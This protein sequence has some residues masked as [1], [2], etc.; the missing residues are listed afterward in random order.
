MQLSASCLCCQK[1]WKFHCSPKKICCELELLVVVGWLFV[2]LGVFLKLFWDACLR[3]GW[4]WVSPTFGTFTSSLGPIV[5]CPLSQRGA[6]SDWT[7]KIP[8]VFSIQHLTKKTNAPLMVV[9]KIA[10]SV[11]IYLE[12]IIQIQHNSCPNLS[13]C[14]LF[15]VS[16][17]LQ[18][19]QVRQRFEGEADV[20]NHAIAQETVTTLVG[21][22]GQPIWMRDDEL[23]VPWVV[24]QWKMVGYIPKV[25]ILLEIYTS[26][27][28]EKPYEMGQEGNCLKTKKACTVTTPTICKL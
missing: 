3:V 6:T 7:S 23:L 2:F 25:T 26:I 19:C 28:H 13:E 16:S 17:C 4:F 8:K 20:K 14:L 15:K 21:R 27:F 9:K 5:I 1:L 12:L 10:D 11:Y 22:C 24:V 18:I